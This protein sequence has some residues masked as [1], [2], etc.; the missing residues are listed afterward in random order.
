MSTVSSITIH[1]SYN[2]DTSDYDIAILK[3]ATAVPTS[4][5]IGYATFAAA[6]SDPASG[7]TVTVAGW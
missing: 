4:S 7:S 6:G 5:T 1:P 3:L 2:D